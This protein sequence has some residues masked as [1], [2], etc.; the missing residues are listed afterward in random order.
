MKFQ[1]GVSGNPG[2]LAKEHDVVSVEHWLRKAEREL[3]NKKLSAA[4]RLQWQT[5]II[6]LLLDRKDI[7]AKSKRDESKP[8]VDTD[9]IEGLENGRPGTTAGGKNGLG[10]GPVEVQAFA[11]SAGD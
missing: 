11:D 3:N 1:K 8:K 9:L 5:K 6:A 2:G 4:D 7:P 10:S